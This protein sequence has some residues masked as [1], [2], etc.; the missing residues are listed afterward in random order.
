[1]TGASPPEPYTSVVEDFGE[2]E[3]GGPIPASWKRGPKYPLNQ[4]SRDGIELHHRICDS[5]GT[6]ST[7]SLNK[8][9]PD[10]NLMLHRRQS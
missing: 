2:G 7:L 1:M 8:R 5:G 10:R 6:V 3:R 9:F 4:L